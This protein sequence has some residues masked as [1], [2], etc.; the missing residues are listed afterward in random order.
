MQKTWVQSLQYKKKTKEGYQ[1][2]ATHLTCIFDYYDVGEHE[3][4]Q[5]KISQTWYE[6]PKTM[7][8]WYT[9][10]HQELGE[11]VSGGFMFNRYEL[12]IWMIK[13]YSTKSGEGYRTLWIYLRLTNCTSK[14]ILIL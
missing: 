4:T 6:I 14:Q 8:I 11:G 2:W 13:K 10:G 7:N 9:W 5:S 1:D 12:F 3:N